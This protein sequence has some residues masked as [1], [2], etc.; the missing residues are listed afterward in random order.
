MIELVV[1]T[2]NCAEFN[3]EVKAFAPGSKE[4]G[5]VQGVNLPP[6]SDIPSYVPPPITSVMAISFGS[7][8]KPVYGV[9]TSSGVSAAC[10]PAY[11]E[12][13]DSYRQR[14]ENEVGFQWGKT[15][16]GSSTVASTTGKVTEIRGAALDKFGCICS[17]PHLRLSST[18][19]KV[20]KNYLGSFGHFQYQGMHGGF[21]YYQKT[22]H[23]SSPATT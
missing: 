10:L 23:T 6:L 22:T 4:V 8:G 14:L 11:F 18:D 9:K 2:P 15:K 7:S 13:L 3:F 19:A 5:K 1:T 12:A 17:S 21:P 20:L 16:T